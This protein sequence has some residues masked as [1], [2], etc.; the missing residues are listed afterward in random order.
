MYSDNNMVSSTGLSAV[1]N[2]L[3]GV[4]H[5]NS[6]FIPLVKLKSN[7]LSKRL[8]NNLKGQSNQRS[9]LLD[10]N[11]FFNLI[12]VNITESLT[13]LRSLVPYRQPVSPATQTLCINFSD[14]FYYHPLI[15]ARCTQ[16][17]HMFVPPL[18]FDTSALTQACSVLFLSEQEMPQTVVAMLREANLANILL[19]R[20]HQFVNAVPELLHMHLF[21]CNYSIGING[22][23]P[24]RNSY[25]Y[26]MDNNYRI[27]TFSLPFSSSDTT[28]GSSSY[29]SSSA[30]S[31]SNSSS[32]SSSSPIIPSSINLRRL[33][34][35]SPLSRQKPL[36]HLI[37]S[38]ITST[39]GYTSHTLGLPNYSSFLYHSNSSFTSSIDNSQSSLLFYQSVSTSR[40]MHILNFILNEL[41]LHN[42]DGWDDFLFVIP[43]AFMSIFTGI[44]NI[45]SSTNMIAWKYLSK[46]EVPMGWISPTPFKSTV[47]SL[48]TNKHPPLLYQFINHAICVLDQLHSFFSFIPVEHRYMGITN[49]PLPAASIKVKGMKKMNTSMVISPSHLLNG[50]G[51]FVS[52]RQEIAQI[53]N[54]MAQHVHSETVQLIS[55]SQFNSGFSELSKNSISQLQSFFSL[56]S[57]KNLQS[58]I[59][60]MQYMDNEGADSGSQLSSEENNEETD[61]K[62][63]YGVSRYNSLSSTVNKTRGYHS[64]L[65]NNLKKLIL[66]MHVLFVSY[67][68]IVLSVEPTD[69][70]CR[71]EVPKKALNEMQTKPAL[72]ILFQNS[73]IDLTP[74]TVYDNKTKRLI[75]RITFPSILSYFSLP[76]SLNKLSQKGDVKRSS[77]NEREQMKRIETAKHNNF[78]LSTPYAEI[79]SSIPAISTPLLS[80]DL[81][82]LGKAFHSFFEP[83]F[84]DVI[85]SSLDRSQRDLYGLP[86]LR[87]NI[88]IRNLETNTLHA[89]T[90][91]ALLKS[92]PA[93]YQKYP[94]SL[95]SNGRLYTLFPIS[96][97]ISSKFFS[98]ASI[99]LA[100]ERD[101][102]SAND[103]DDEIMASFRYF[104]VNLHPP[105]LHSLPGDNN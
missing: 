82:H 37:S 101:T 93:S 60:N 84:M 13:L 16:E 67:G 59:D 104:T 77:A 30:S 35:T 28:T 65:F 57:S 61:Y 90:P 40:S 54:S 78:L 81:P 47:S 87:V 9:F 38:G 51:F 6:G 85:P 92:F 50:P 10:I 100:D 79:L 36:H 74:F 66:K 70:K 68:D 73:T 55:R 72:T 99:I 76:D 14:N 52:L 11:P 3:K 33:N 15:L 48:I 95:S 94:L 69:Y 1:E 102:D 88:N 22:S 62:D 2:L 96:L 53:V 89:I 91:N 26:A 97:N 86:L 19:T 80:H 34:Y 63:E 12:P 39:S 46:G 23:I 45:P 4:L 56:G 43:Q 24:I 27:N 103:K 18:L 31:F 32:S 49:K 75:S 83:S 98:E 8:T 71:N 42:N 25:V 44:H 5:M 64:E 21:G 105:Y 7:S 17:L 58:N 20:V 41:F 29:S